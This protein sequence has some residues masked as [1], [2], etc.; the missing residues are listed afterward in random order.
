M[1][2]GYIDST[3]GLL[4]KKQTNR[5]IDEWSIVEGERLIV[6]IARRINHSCR[7][8]CD[9]YMSGGFKGRPCVR[10]RAVQEIA[11]GS[12]LMVFYSSNYFGDE[13]VDCLCGHNDLHELKVN[14]VETDTFCVAVKSQKARNEDSSYH[15]SNC[16][17]VLLF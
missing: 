5:E 12:Q 10:L 2:F 14:D 16:K 3:V 1:N 7:P 6:G 13:I 15:A 8:N 11:D 9:Y 4:V 17:R